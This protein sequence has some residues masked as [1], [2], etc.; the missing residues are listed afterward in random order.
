MDERGRVVSRVSVEKFLSHS[1]GNLCREALPL[2]QKTEGIK[3]VMKERCKND[4]LSE[5]FRRRVSKRF[6]E[7]PYCASENF[8]CLNFVWIGR[9]SGF[10]DLES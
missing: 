3:K 10:R 4:F 5:V 6:E 9:K 8:C 1:T 7:E 2:F